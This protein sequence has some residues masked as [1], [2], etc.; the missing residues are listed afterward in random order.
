MRL[1]GIA[2]MEL[3]SIFSCLC[4]SW[5][6][7]QPEI[8]SGFVSGIRV[9]RADLA[10]FRDFRN[11]APVGFRADETSPGLWS[12]NVKGDRAGSFPVMAALSFQGATLYTVSSKIAIFVHDMF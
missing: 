3:R 10:L 6:K 8:E 1:D 5:R 12:A 7:I 9:F 4:N 2:T 11:S